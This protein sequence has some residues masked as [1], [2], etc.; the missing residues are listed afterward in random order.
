MNYKTNNVLLFISIAFNIL[1]MLIVVLFILRKGGVFYIKSKISDIVKKSVKNDLNI[2]AYYKHKKSQFEILPL[3]NDS[4]I[5]LGDS[6]T[7]EGEWVELLGNCHIKNR[8]IS[9]DT[10]GRILNRLDAII[11]TKPKQVFLMVGINDFVNEKKSIEEV[12]NKYKIILEKL[13]SQTSQTEVFIQS[14][15]PVNNN[16]TAFQQN[17]DTV[18]KF[19]LKLQ[20]LTKQFNYQYIDIF[21]PLADSDN[22]LDARYTTDG[23]HLNG[24]AYLIWKEAVSQYVAVN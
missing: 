22:Q 19:N 10:T 4:I 8:G 20:E 3:S 13:Q 2:N 16:L 6:L 14:V 12:L 18:I 7:D 17:N 24:K 11:Q 15:L 9:G 1:F 5:F 21:S 23:L